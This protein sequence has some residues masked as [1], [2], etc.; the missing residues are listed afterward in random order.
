M[1]GL[2]DQTELSDADIYEILPRPEGNDAKLIGELHDRMKC[3]RKCSANERSEEN[4]C[5][6]AGHAG[7]TI[8]PGVMSSIVTIACRAI[9]KDPTR[10]AKILALVQKVGIA[11]PTLDL[12]EARTL[13]KGRC[14]ATFVEDKHALSLKAGGVFMCNHAEECPS[15]KDKLETIENTCRIHE[16]YPELAE[17]HG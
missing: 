6:V 7:T 16:I 17:Q 2:T 3:L 13:R 9:A 1:I 4:I 10:E 11:I 5:K 15:I 8:C 12:E 14:F